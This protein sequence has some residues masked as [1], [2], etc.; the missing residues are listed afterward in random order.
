MEEEGRPSRSS[1]RRGK[2]S[3]K[4]IEAQEQRAEEERAREERRSNKNKRPSA[5][6]SERYDA[7]KA[8]KKK[9]QQETDLSGD[10]ELSEDG[11]GGT[12]YVYNT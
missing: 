9:R 3:V 2:A 12:G 10:E 7:A 6:P 5:T 4:V 1:S 8:A 11:S